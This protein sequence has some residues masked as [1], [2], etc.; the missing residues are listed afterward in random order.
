V[1]LYATRPGFKGTHPYRPVDLPAELAAEIDDH[2]SGLTRGQEPQA[3][4]LWYDAATQRCRHY[5]FRPQVC[6]D[7][8]LAG[9]ACLTLRRT[10]GVTGG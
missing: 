5:E 2:F 4:C 7:Y 9:R 1:L 8:E 6:R 3:Q 10:H